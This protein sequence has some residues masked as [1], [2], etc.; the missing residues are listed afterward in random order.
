ML[1]QL[2]FLS[3]EFTVRTERHDLHEAE[4]GGGGGRG[5]GLDSEADI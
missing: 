1:L 4:L 5:G 2:E 3:Q